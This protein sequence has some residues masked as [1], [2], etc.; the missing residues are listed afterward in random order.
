M[1]RKNSPVFIPIVIVM[2]VLVSVVASPVEIEGTLQNVTGSTLPGRVTVVQEIPHLIFTTYEVDDDGLFRFTNDYDGEL[3]IHAVAAGHPPAERVI[4]AG[5]IGPVRVNFVLPLG[6]DVEVRV[7]D[8]SG[9]AVSGADVRVRYH[10][11][12][13]PTRRV[14]FEREDRT[15]GDGRMVLRAVGVDVPFVV[16]VLAPNYPPVSSG[17]IKLSGGETHIEDIDVGEPAGTVVVKV[18]DATGLFPVVDATVMLLAD[19]SSLLAEDRDSWL[20]HLAYRQR[21]VTSE[22]GNVQFSGV[23]PGKIIVQV[24]TVTSVVKQSAVVGFNEELQITLEV[25]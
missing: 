3:V 12:Y 19:P 20:H 11:P 17:L 24:K 18:L 2:A 15:D 5:T 14:D 8:W 7:V 13:K 1:R 23:P 22:L 10:E 9:R 16:D 4:S 21:A 25:P 6:Q